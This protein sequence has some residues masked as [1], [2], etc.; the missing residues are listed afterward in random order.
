MLAQSRTHWRTVWAETTHQMQSLR[1]NPVCA[2]EEFRLKQRAD[3]PGLQADLTFDP[4]EDI[5]APYIA[6]GISPK[7]A[8]LREQ[9]EFALRNGGGIRP[10]RFEAATPHERHF[11]R[12]CKL[13]A[14]VLVADS[15]TVT[16][17]VPRRR[18]SPFV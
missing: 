3:N 13:E 9:G 15:P 10:R 7:V 17:W 16:C 1:D 6:K 12:T 11:S 18:L 4:A 8:I 5:A 2:D 14:L